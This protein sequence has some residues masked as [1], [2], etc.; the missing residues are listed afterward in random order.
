MNANE[1]ITNRAIELIGGDRFAAE[2]PIHPNDHVNM[3]QSTNDMFP[4]AIHVAVAVAIQQR[5]DSRAG[6]IAASAGRQGR[7]SGTRSSRSA[8]RIW[9]TP[10]RC[11]WA[12]RSA[13]TPGNWSCRSS[14]PGGASSAVLELPA[15]GTAV[16]TGIN[17]H[18]E[19]GRRVAEVLADETGIPFVEAANHFEANAK[20]DG[21]VE[22]HGQLR[23]DRRHAVQRGQQHPLAGLAARAA[24]STKS[25]CPTASPA[26]RSCPARS[27][28]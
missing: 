24:A 5:A 22:C 11:G 3:G 27:T 6:A 1:V 19:F 20:R 2:K 25:S 23:A 8:A 7:R 21:L 9:P 12:R 4:T 17:T 16:G 28:R 14:G 10:R 26:A 18:P 13:A 15:G